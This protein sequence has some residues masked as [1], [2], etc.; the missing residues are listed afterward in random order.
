MT[1]SRL[2]NP[3]CPMNMT[4][5]TLDVNNQW[6]TIK[7][8]DFKKNANSLNE[9][10][11]CPNNRKPRSF[12]QTMFGFTIDSSLVINFNGKKLT[13]I[14]NFFTKQNIYNRTWYNNIL[15][16]FNFVNLLVHLLRGI[17]K[18]LKETAKLIQNQNVK[19]SV[20]CRRVAAAYWWWLHSCFLLTNRVRCRSQRWFPFWKI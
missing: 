13:L 2:T 17:H 3:Q 12:I 5:V 15:V 11:C 20:T 1:K 19:N 10:G 6:L 9:I 7:P 16:D 18:L 4:H 8:N 14:K